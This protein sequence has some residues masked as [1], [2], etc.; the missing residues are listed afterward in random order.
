MIE[1]SHYQTLTSNSLLAHVAFHNQLSDAQMQQLLDPPPYSPSSYWAFDALAEQLKQ[2]IANHEK[3]IVC[4]DYDADGICAT[5]ILVKSL[6]DAGATVGYYI[7]HRFEDGYGLSVATV[8]AALQKEY[9]HFILVDNGVSAHAALAAIHAGKAHAY[10]LDHHEMTTEPLCDVLIH[11]SLLEAPYQDSCGSALA[12]LLSTRFQPDAYL[13]CLA[14]IATIAD[15][16]DLWGYNRWIV[17]EG[18]ALFNANRYPAIQ[19]LLDRPDPVDESSLSFQIIPKIN[20]VGR[21]NESFSVNQLVNYLLTDQVAHLKTMAQIIADINQKRK[22]VNTAMMSKTVK[23][24]TDP[25]AVIVVDDPE[26]HEGIVGITA[27][28]LVAQTGK[29][30]IVLAHREG[31]YKGSCRSPLG[32]D[33]REILESALPFV[34]RYGGHALAAGIEIASQHYEAFKEALYASTDQRTWSTG[35]RRS[36]RFETSLFTL[37]SFRSLLAFAPFGQGFELP[38][39]EIANA[40]VTRFQTLKNGV[41]WETMV[42]DCPV[43]VLAFR[44]VPPQASL[45][46][47][48]SATGRLSLS[49][50]RG[51]TRFTLMADD[52]A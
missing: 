52:V 6:R 18:L 41:K 21:M 27:G 48:L 37:S 36:L 19:A 45:K 17:L 14:A 43:D 2:A 9:T 38:P 34:Q 25:H 23:A 29:P 4:G 12:Y 47:I 15:V 32:T 1:L 13:L 39:I 22:A 7:P 28:Q 5:T 46:T 49:E 24:I 42:E 10:I 3:I 20:A 8:E 51:Q 50:F 31:Y 11:P 16:V 30:A 44:S 40:R 35:Q 33:L 26:F